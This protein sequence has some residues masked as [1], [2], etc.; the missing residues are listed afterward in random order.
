MKPIS[1]TYNQDCI[2][3][4]KDYPDNHFQLAIV[5][6]PYGVDAPNMSMGANKSKNKSGTSDSV[7]NQLR[8][9]RFSK[10][11]GKLKNRA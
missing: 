7:A 11:S 10:G 2:E 9:A 4:M 5:D 8:K 1:I 6:P 3:A